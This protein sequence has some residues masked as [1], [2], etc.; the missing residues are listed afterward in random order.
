MLIVKPDADITGYEHYRQGSLINMHVK[1]LKKVSSTE[2]KNIHKELY[3]MTKWEHHRYARLENKII[4][5]H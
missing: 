1:I 4:A 3:N 2:S 5:I